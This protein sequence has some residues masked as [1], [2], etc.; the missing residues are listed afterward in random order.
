MENS[1]Q[2][3]GCQTLFDNSIVLIKGEHADMNFGHCQTSNT[4]FMRLIL[5]MT[6]DFCHSLKSNMRIQWL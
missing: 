6:W 1:W 4:C 2:K 5:W 3:I